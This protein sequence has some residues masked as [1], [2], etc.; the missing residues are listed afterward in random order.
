MDF[1]QQ[2]NRELEAKLSQ[3]ELKNSVLTKQAED[4]GQK[5]S[6]MCVELAEIEGLVKQMSTEREAGEKS[7]HVRAALA[8]VR[9]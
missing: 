5:N 3:A 4:L 2:A 8:E 7:L 9:T 6:Q 1:L